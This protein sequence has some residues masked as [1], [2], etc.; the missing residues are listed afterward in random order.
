MEARHHLAITDRYYKEKLT[1]VFGFDKHIQTLAG[2]GGFL[3]CVKS[4]I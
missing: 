2:L 1:V 4:G 3:S